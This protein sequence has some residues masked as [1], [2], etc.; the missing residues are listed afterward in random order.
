MKQKHGHLE[1]AKALCAAGAHLGDAEVES[2][3]V[4][5]EVRKAEK[6]ND[7]ARI[8]AWRFARQGQRM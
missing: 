3:D 8:E 7:R 4:D 1:V 6:V 2:G 5:G